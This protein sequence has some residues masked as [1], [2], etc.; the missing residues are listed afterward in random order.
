MSRLKKSLSIVALLL[1]V[2]I[3]FTA[4]AL[5][6]LIRSKG[7]EALS[8]SY[9]RTLVVGK[10][11]VN[12]FTWTVEARGISLSEKK[13]SAIFFACSSVRVKI[14]PASIYHRAPVL[15][16][17][18]IVSPS[19]HLIRNNASTYNF[20]DL[21]PITKGRP[22]DKPAR[23]SLNNIRLRQGSVDF[24]DR[25]SPEE[26]RQAVRKL[27]ISIP[28]V[29]NLPYLAESYITPGMSALVDG[30]P[31]SLEGKIKPFAKYQEVSI[32]VKLTDLDLTDYA[33]YLPATVPV[34]L[35]SGKLTTDLR[36]IHRAV[37]TG[38]PAFIVSGLA[39]VDHLDLRDRQKEPLLA[40]DSASLR[41]RQARIL[42]GIYDI[43]AVEITGPRVNLSRNGEGLFNVMGLASPAKK[44]EAPLPDREK[45]K[46][47]LPLPMKE[48]KSEEIVVNVAKVT[49]E[50]GKLRFRDELPTGG[51]GV[52]LDAITLNVS[53]FSTLKD[54]NARYLL[55]FV[56]SRK[57]ALEF[58]GSFSAKPAAT[59]T[60]AKVSGLLL[61]AAYPYLTQ[62]LTSPVSGR[63]D[64]SAGI[65]YTPQAGVEITDLTL[66]LNK[67]ALGFGGKDGVRIPEITLKGG[68]VGLK[69]RRAG[70]ESVAV[71]GGSVIVS[72]FADGKLSP[73]SL[74]RQTVPVTGNPQPSPLPFRYAVKS[75]TIDGVDLS[76]TDLQNKGAPTMTLGKVALSLRNLTAPG[77]PVMPFK[78]S[79]EFAGG[80][81]ASGGKLAL[82]PFQFSGECS[83]KGIPLTALDAYFPEELHL[84]VADGILESNLS[85][86]LAAA[87]E[88]VSGTFQGDLTV[89]RFHGLDDEEGDDLLKWENLHLAGISGTMKPF[90]LNLEQVSLTD[91]FARVTVEKDSSLNLQKIYVARQSPAVAASLPGQPASPPTPAPSAGKIAIRA[92]TLQGGTLDF[93]DRHIKPEF[94]ATM[95]RLGGRID[96]LSSEQMKFADVDLRGNLRNQSPL[97]IT[98]KINP[99]RGDL[100]LDMKVSFSDIELSPMSPY[101]GTYLGYAVDK[102]KLYLDLLYRIENK[103]LVSENKLFIDQLTFGDKVESVK[104][105]NLPVRLAIAL[106][107]DSKGEIHLDLPVTGRTDDPKFSIWK[108]IG[109]VLVNLLEK[110]ATAPFKLLGS[111]FGSSENFSS[112]EF[113]PGS[114]ELAVSEQ[115][116]L[117]KLGKL[118]ADRPALNLEVSGFVD[119]ERD[120]E[121]YREELLRKKMKNEKF[122]ALVKEKKNLPGQTAEELTVTGEESS[123]LL[124][125]VYK[126]EK[127]PKPRN[128]IGLDKELPEQEMKKLIFANTTV[129]N[130]ELSQLA[131]ERVVAV[132]N[133]LVSGG[134]VARERIF[135]KSGILSGPPREG[136]RAESRVEFGLGAK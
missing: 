25:L 12:P 13:S 58:T 62:F 16:S 100:F 92:V 9:G 37:A 135:E 90:S 50:Q 76:F 103:Q 89:K 107:K 24:T 128:V 132:K 97:G 106:L 61:E 117:T 93:S 66:I 46:K 34:R 10:L 125:A 111:L 60:Q 73:L 51:F 40:L 44:V 22:D 109:Q 35:V 82:A 123:R 99:L 83:L 119:K 1:T 64:G 136:G 80:S 47:S 84:I 70:V 53:D 5:P 32:E 116:K 19:I 39:R 69:E 129:G 94:S 55:S 15:S 131:R 21:I 8:K 78:F 87:N 59:V 75:I 121:G 45:S 18:D 120:P 20:S 6:S 77:R 113:V 127:F 86:T 85:L 71:K 27:E 4:L 28:F 29:S 96:G 49:L 68:A 36:I 11:S 105:T 101:S 114:V 74:L 102:G 38:E 57:E 67:L 2:T 26:Q 126:K 91:Y 112:V 54:K 56:T 108:V 3:L 72:R 110:A 81:L 14:S 122:L 115:Q 95:Y 41:I 7:A 30:A 88:G 79:A 134:G 98:G 130:E 48:R 118:L 42:A 104:A 63:V 17:V 65:T 33:A 31:F 133:Y 124:T 43:D 52:D 23:F